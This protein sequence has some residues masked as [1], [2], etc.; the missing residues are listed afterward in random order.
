MS[1]QTQKQTRERERFNSTR[2]NR[3]VTETDVGKYKHKH[4]H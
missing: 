3:I 4:E 2:I 1:K